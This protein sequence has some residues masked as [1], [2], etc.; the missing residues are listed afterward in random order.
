MTWT[1][2]SRTA[3][4]VTRSR[5]QRDSI[6]GIDGYELQVRLPHTPWPETTVTTDI[7]TYL[8]DEVEGSA[9]RLTFGVRYQWRVRVMDGSGQVRPWSKRQS[10]RLPVAVPGRPQHVTAKTAGKR[11][12]IR[13]LAPAPRYFPVEDYTVFYSTN[14]KRWKPLGSVNALHVSYRIRRHQHYWFIISARSR[15]GEGQPVRVAVG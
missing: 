9:L 13:W 3:M 7:T 6:G 10:F 11:V 15:G 12:V 14:R 5:G 8:Q 4:Q 1:P 2:Y